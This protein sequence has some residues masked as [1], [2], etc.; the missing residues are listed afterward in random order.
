MAQKQTGVALLLGIRPRDY[1]DKELRIEI[2]EPAY[3]QTDNIAV[4]SRSPESGVWRYENGVAGD[5]RVGG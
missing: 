1:A 3:I 5:I 4:S 2:P